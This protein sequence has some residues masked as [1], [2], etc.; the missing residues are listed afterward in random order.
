MSAPVRPPS[1]PSN[2]PSEMA[3]PPS[4]GP[5]PPSA[6]PRPPF[7]TPRRPYDA[8]SRHP[9]DASVNLS[10]T[11][12][13]PSDA[14]AYSSAP[15]RH[16]KDA[17]AHPV[18]IPRP[19]SATLRPPIATVKPTP[20]PSKPVTPQQPVPVT[21][22][23][24]VSGRSS[25]SDLPVD[26]QVLLLALADEYINKAHGMSAMLVR[27]M[28]DADLEQYQKLIA[29]GLGC[30]ESVLRNFKF[31]DPRIEARL[32]HRYCS[33]L[34]DETENESEAHE[35]LSKTIRLCERHRL[36][37]LRYSLINVQLRF[38][39]KFRPGAALKMLD[40]ILELVETYKHVSWNYAMRFLRVSLALQA[41]QLD[42]PVAL[43]HL[44]RI[45][46]LAQSHHHIPILAA[47]AAFEALVH[48]KSD[49]QE[50]VQSAQSALADAR[51]H[52]LD[53]SLQNI[54]QLAAMLD[55]LDLCC[56]LIRFSPEQAVMKMKQMQ[57]VMDE[58]S[59]NKS[60]RADGSFC[61][62]IDGAAD[63]V[64]QDIRV[65]SGGLFERTSKGQRALV[66]TWI[67]KSELFALGYLFSGM[68]T[69]HKNS[70]DRKSERY[71]EEGSKI[72][73]GEKYAAH[74]TRIISL[75]IYSQVQ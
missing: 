28:Q 38:H 75:T 41:S 27:S 36:V 72:S 51:K 59:S 21:P 29:A 9:S 12:K 61:V 39:L 23:A 56:D 22:T 2:Q 45:S 13:H 60:W 62:P 33:L 49:S 35:M 18:T 10:T 40:G 7:A 34:L 48:L 66:L 16:P 69:A 19:Q 20:I 44:R 31:P 30:I 52:Q 70:H 1:V 4:A 42:M 37:D 65:D 50:A 64:D 74:T 6:G 17:Y 73:T 71:L 3:R 8:T 32:V 11:H 55:C 47:S 46:Q 25:Q 15:P 58:A 67:K 26:Y 68:A 63:A 43:Q 14:S 57:K 54:P 5:R 53:P 24:T